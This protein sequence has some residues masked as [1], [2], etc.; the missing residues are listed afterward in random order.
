MYLILLPDEMRIACK[1]TNFQVGCLVAELDYAGM[2]TAMFPNEAKEW[3]RY[4][5]LDLMQLLTNHGVTGG[6]PLDYQGLIALCKELGDSIPA[7]QRSLAA[8]EAKAGPRPLPGDIRDIIPRRYDQP[9]SVPCVGAPPSIK[10]SAP[11]LPGEARAAPTKGATGRVH[12]IAN[13]LVAC[14]DPS[15]LNIKELRKQVIDA[16]VAEGLNP[17][18]AATQFGKWKAGKGL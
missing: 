8:L 7:D 11:K 9:V 12:E 10:H 16:C 4:G 18:T 5:R 1:I 3:A 13:S 17:G 2:A 14:V 15:K 6:N